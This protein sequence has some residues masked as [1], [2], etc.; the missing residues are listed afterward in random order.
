MVRR[1]LGSCDESIKFRRNL[2]VGEVQIPQRF[3]VRCDDLLESLIRTEESCPRESS[4]PHPG[5]N[6][7]FARRLITGRLGLLQPG[8]PAEWVKNYCRSV[9]GRGFCTIRLGGGGVTQPTLL[10]AA[11][12]T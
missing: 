11:G 1:G 9:R 10:T 3:R 8:F 5:F 2:R 6:L 7:R 4:G 12:V